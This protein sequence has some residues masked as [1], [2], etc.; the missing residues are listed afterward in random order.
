MTTADRPTPPAGDRAPPRRFAVVALTLFPSYGL[1]TNVAIAP[2]ELGHAPGCWSAG[3]KVLGLSLAPQGSAGSYA[4]RDF[5][6]EYATRHGHL[7]TVA[8][9]PVLGA[10]FAVPFLLAALLCRRGSVGWIVTLAVGTWC[11]G[12][13]GA[14][15]FLGGLVPFGDA[16]F[17]TELGVPR[18]ALVV[19][20]LPLVVAFLALFASLLRGIGLRRDD[21]Y[22]RWVLTVEAGLL[23]YLAAVTAARL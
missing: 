2:P 17:L 18:W 1:A 6:V 9:G 8:G 13:N 12:N 10:A 21:T 5:S 7:L 22:W 16:L 23:A 11:V 19:A 20:G 4:A 15:L 14:Y 3:G